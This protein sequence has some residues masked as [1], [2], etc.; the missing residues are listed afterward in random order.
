ML[1]ALIW[2]EVREIWIF[3]AVGLAINFF[4]VLG[5]MGWPIGLPTFDYFAPFTSNDPSLFLVVYLSCLLAPSTGWWQ[6]YHENNRGTNQFL[7]HR[8]LSRIVISMTKISV[9]LASS[10]LV[11]FSPLIVYALWA[12]TPG[13]HASPFYWS[14]TNSYFIGAAAAPTLYLG[15][16][17]AELQPKNTWIQSMIVF[18]V[19]ATVVALILG[20]LDGNRHTLIVVF[21]M[22][23]TIYCVGILYVVK[24]R[25]WA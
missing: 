7:F 8:P 9:G 25:D 17:L 12:T 16:C 24:S 21:P 11:S 5:N 3:A 15:G 23:I 19:L 2:K 1:R 4:I 22:I 20:N 14:M 18:G 6:F 10:F 13:T